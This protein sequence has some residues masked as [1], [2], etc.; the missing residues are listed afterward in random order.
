MDGI[1]T[2]TEMRRHWELP[3][4][5][6]TAYAT[7]DVLA[8][9]KQAKT[10]GDITKPFQ[11]K[12][13]NATVAVALHQYQITRDLFAE[14]GWLRTLLEGMNDGLIATDASGRVRYLNPRAESLTGYTL[15]KALD[16]PIEE[17]YS[18]RTEDGRP[19]PECQ[20]RRVLAIGKAIGRQRFILQAGERRI[21]V[22]DSAA[23]IRDSHQRI[24]G[25][26]TVIVDVTEQ[27][28]A[29]SERARLLGELERSNRDLARLSHVVSHDMQGPVPTVRS[30]AELVSHRLG[31]DAPKEVRELIR[32][33]TE[34]VQGMERLIRSLLLYAQVGK[35]QITREPIA[36]GDLVSAVVTMLSA[37]IDEADACI[38]CGQLP[39]ISADRAQF[40][41]LIQNLIS[42]ALRY[43]RLDQ[44]PRS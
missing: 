14:Q 29:E 32:H 25:A 12:E 22:E 23:P 16:R 18:L 26:V 6:V 7:Q 36:A 38:E 42:N 41:Q 20:L 33:I 21:M 24:I 31:P 43:P 34:S 10:Y 39:V 19:L 37:A 11:R 40:E 15:S 17:I 9:A 35:G 30:L 8:R 28:R 1:E 13:L 2:A 27:Q 44:A 5:F 3:F 4:V